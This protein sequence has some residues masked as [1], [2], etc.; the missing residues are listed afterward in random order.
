M[1]TEI[2]PILNKIFKIDLQH[3]NSSLLNAMSSPK[4]LAK[5]PC[6]CGHR[7]AIGCAN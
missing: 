6:N 7:C 1:I 2:K 5:L 4:V 3:I